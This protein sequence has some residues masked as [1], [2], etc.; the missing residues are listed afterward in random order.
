[1]E[2]QFVWAWPVVAF[3]ALAVP[4]S[5]SV[6]QGTPRADTMATAPPEAVT[7][8]ESPSAAGA[9]TRTASDVRTTTVGTKSGLDSAGKPGGATS[10]PAPP[11]SPYKPLYFDNDFTYL[12]DPAT[13]EFFLGDALKQRQIAPSLMMDAGGEYRL[14]DHHEHN[15]R[16]APLVGSDLDG[17]DDDFL[18]GRTRTYLN[19]RWGN[20]FRFYGEALDAVSNFENLPARAIEENHWD[21]LNL[22]GDLTILEASEGKLIGRVGRQEQLFG[23]ER[24][25]SPLDWANT[26]RTFDGAKLFWQDPKWTI[27]G[28]WL[29]PVPFAQHVGGDTEFNRPD[30]S[31]EFVGLYATYK[32]VAEHTYDAYYLRL[33]EYDAPGS[34]LTPVNFDVHL[35]GGR[36]LG[37]RDAWLWELE[38]GYQFG[39]YGNANQSAGFT[40]VGLG[41]ELSDN[42]HKPTIWLYYDWASGD[43]DPADGTHGTFNQLFP[44]VHKYFGFM[45]LVARQNIHDVNTIGTM[46]LN[47]KQKLLVWWHLF[48]L[49]QP[50]DA[51]YNAAGIPIR[52]SPTGAAGRYVGQEIDLLW[53][54]QVNPRA[55]VLFGYSHFFQGSFVEATNPAGVSG[56]ADFYY[57]QWSWRF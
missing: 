5:L 4:Q 44:L 51:L 13:T 55:D 45:D 53:T 54:I 57:S 30:L 19:L 52:S 56:N 16:G 32:P 22:F 36:W 10:P 27:S 3:L 7:P 9:T 2:L 38:G 1:M 11:P 17:L 33:A 6:A 40:V 31:Q 21:A 18:L 12:R 25:I 49:D 47:P 14:R 35:F 26:R 46:Q 15:F 50:R 20:T 37:R 39:S 29:R 34:R 24:L 8:V 48:Y 41:H 42:C 28:F 23:A 43:R